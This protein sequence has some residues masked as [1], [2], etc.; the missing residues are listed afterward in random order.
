MITAGELAQFL[1]AK[2]EGSPGVQV[3]A[4][5][6]IEEAERGTISFLANPRYEKYAYAC[7]ASVLLVQSD[8]EPKEP[9]L[10]EALLRVDDVY[11]ALGLL[12]QRF[13]PEEQKQGQ[14]QLSPQ[15]YIHPE[16]KLASTGIRIDAFA[17]I[18]QG[19]ELAE[20]TT[21][22]AHVWL[23]ADMQIGAGTTIYSGAKLYKGC[24][25]GRHCIIHANAVLGADG[26]GFAP[27][28]DGSYKKIAQLGIVELE[29][30]VEVGA[31]TC[32]DRATMGRT[33]VK[34]GVKLDNLI[35]IAHNV[36]IGEHTVIAAQAG[37][38]GSVR[39]GKGCMVGGQAG[40]AGHLHIADGTKIQ[41]QSG[42]GRHIKEE[43]KAFYG[44]PALPYNDYLRA[45][46]IFSRLPELD[47]RLRILEKKSSEK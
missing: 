8:F 42:I 9:L 44:S 23:E 36:E 13:A 27:Q 25:I 1:G 15:A 18:G 21:I 11:A 20:N 2:L 46:S 32:I 34:K 31:N 10:V 30:E 12:L 38:A 6:K 40:F 22:H 37:V 17:Y 26:F 14:N 3:Y 24:K 35:Q 29:D 4:P 41:A 33:L 43:N 7:Q 39:L 16:A 47:K 28:P 19:V 45:Y 5:A